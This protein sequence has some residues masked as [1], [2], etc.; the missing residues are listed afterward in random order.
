MSKIKICG[1]SRKCDIDYVNELMPDY[2]GFVFAKSRRQIDRRKAEKLREMLN[3]NIQTVGVFVNE[4]INKVAYMANNSIIDMIQLHGS[5]DET[6]VKSLRYKTDAKI[7]KAFK[8]NSYE[9][10]KMANESDAEYILLDNGN[11]GTGECF[12]WSYVDNIDRPYFLAGGINESNLEAALRLQPYAIDL[13]SGIETDGF[14][15]YNKI[16]NVIRTVRGS[17][18]DHNKY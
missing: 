12:D 2:I 13:S 16:K 5:E 8:I 4:D 18:P 9:D 3:E 17:L 1:L 10:I 11:G 7:I 14:K 15:D 6:Y